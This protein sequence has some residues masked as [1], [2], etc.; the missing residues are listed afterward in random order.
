MCLYGE[1]AINRKY[2][3]N[4][5]NGGNIPPILDIRTKYVPISCGKCIECKR[6]KARDWQ[7]RLTEEIKSNNTKGYFV[8]LTFS[9]ESIYKIINSK[10]TKNWPGLKNIE[11]YSLDNGIAT[12]AV[13]LFLENWRKKYNTSLRH[14]LATE[15]GHEGTEN[16]HLHGIIWTNENFEVIRNTWHYG[17]V[18][19]RPH[20][21]EKNY[22]SERTINYIIKYI[23]K[24]DEDHPNY[25]SI[26][27]ASH[28]PGIGLNYINTYN[29]KLNKFKGANTKE[30]YTTSNGREVPLPI[31][32]KNK[33][34][35]DEQKEQLWLIKLDKN[36]RYIMGEK[37]I[38]DEEGK[39][40]HRTLEY[41]RK[42]NKE[43]GYGNNE[44]DWNKI[45]YENA[46]RKLLYETRLKNAPPA[47]QLNMG[48]DKDGRGKTHKATQNRPKKNINKIAKEITGRNL[49][50]MIGI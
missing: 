37:V 45:Q 23:N 8:T 41:Y 29:G 49:S 47:G 34:Y 10:P 35:T 14:W 21:L 19:P 46:R 24:T 30:T 22:V 39:Q 5:K 50:D 26:I 25:D 12:R 33:L 6:A 38:N 2:T 28:K 18:Y 3:D 20:E 7:I 36:E 44:K 11:G 48:T 32:Y 16:I 27:L 1:L 17:Y 42:I 13:R 43:L 4:K 9:D 40:L 15:L 31:Y